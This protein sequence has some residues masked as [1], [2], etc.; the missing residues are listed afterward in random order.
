M[1][2]TNKS[3]QVFK[4][5]QVSKSDQI[6]K[7]DQVLSRTRYKL[8]K[9][10]PDVSTVY[11][12]LFVSNSTTSHFQNRFQIATL[13]LQLDQVLKIKQ[14]KITSCRN[15]F[16]LFSLSD[17]YCLDSPYSWRIYASMCLFYSLTHLSITANGMSYYLW[18]L[19]L[20]MFHTCNTNMCHPILCASFQSSTVSTIYCWNTFLLIACWIADGF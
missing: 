4:S 6:F 20:Y 13:N 5:D 18:S 15:P 14:L 11:L 10:L 12:Q 8:N 3:D 19:N 17:R 16:I 2:E 7:S 1:F 9:S